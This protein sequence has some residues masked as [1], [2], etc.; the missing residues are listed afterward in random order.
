MAF[1]KMLSN[2]PFIILTLPLSCVV[3][4]P[5][6]EPNVE[7]YLEENPAFLQKFVVQHLSETDIRELYEHWF[8]V[9]SIGGV[10]EG[11]LSETD[12]RELYEH[13]FQVRSLLI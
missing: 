3:R 12:I 5:L 13:W 8:Q 7:R 9:S 10:G 4:M 2:A 1:Y 11:N 6:S